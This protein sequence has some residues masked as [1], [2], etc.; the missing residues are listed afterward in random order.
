MGGVTSSAARPVAVPAPGAQLSGGTVPQYD[1]L[2]CLIAS[3]DGGHRSCSR[4]CAYG[5]CVWTASHQLLHW[6]ARAFSIPQSNNAM[7]AQGLLSC[8]R[9]LRARFPTTTSHVFGDSSVVINQ[10]LGRHSCGSTRLQP[11]I[12]AIRCLGTGRPL[13]YLRHIRR[14][15]SVASDALCNWIMDTTASGMDRT[16]SGHRWPCPPSYSLTLSPASMTAFLPTTT[17]NPHDGRAHAIYLWDLVLQELCTLGHL[18][19][20]RFMPS[21]TARP[22]HPEVF[23]PRSPECITTAARLLSSDFDYRP[24]RTAVI[25]G[26]E[27]CVPSDVFRRLQEAADRFQVAFPADDVFLTAGL[28]PFTL[29]EADARVLD[30]LIA[31]P[32][33]GIPGVLELFRGQTPLDYRPNKAL[34]P[35]LYRVHLPTYPQL[36]L[37]CAIAQHGLIP[38]WTKSGERRGVRPVPD[39]YIGA[40]TGASI[41][42]DKLLVDY[43]KGRCI[44]AS[45]TTLVQDPFFHSSAFALVLKKDKPIHLD[46][47]II[48]DLSAPMGLSVNNYTDFALSPDATWD[49]FL[50]IAL[51]IRELR[52]RYPGCAIYAMTADIADAFHHVPDHARHAS[53]FGGGGGGTTA[54]LTRNRIRHG[55]LWVDCIARFLRCFRTGMVSGYAETFWIFQWV[56]DIV[57]IEVDIDNPLQEAAKRLRD[58]VKLV[59]CSDGWHEGKFTTWSRE[60]HAVGIDW[61]IPS[62]TISVPQRKIDK[63]RKVVSETKKKRFVPMKQ[64]DSVVGVLR[65]V[66]SFIPTTKPFIQRLVAVQT[67]CRSSRSPGVPMSDFLQK[68]LLW[69][70]DLVFQNELSS[71]PMRLFDH[72]P[73]VDNAWLIRVEPVSLTI[74]SMAMGEHL[75]M[76]H[77]QHHD[78]DTTVAKILQRVV[79]RWGPVLTKEACWRHIVIHS[80]RRWITRVIDKMNCR[81]SE[82]QKELRLKKFTFWQSFCNDFGFPVW[83]DELS[84]TEQARIVGLYAGLC[85]SEGHNKFQTFDGKMA[86]VVF[87]H[88]AIRNARLNYHDPEFELITQGY[89]RSNSHV[90][91]K[92]P[93]TAQMLLKMRETLGTTDAH[94][95]LLWYSI[96]LAF[97][98]L[99]RSSEL[100]GPVS[101]DRSTGTERVHC[102]KAHNVSLKDRHGQAVSPEDS[103]AHVVEV[104]FESHKGDKV[105]QGVTIRH[106]K[107]DAPV[108]CPVAAAQSCLRIRSRWIAEGVALGPYITSIS[109]GETVKKSRVSKLIKTTA[110]NMGFAPKDY[111]AHS[112]RIGGACALLAAGKSDLVIRLMGR[113]SSWCFTVYTRLK[114]AIIRDAASS[115]IKASTWEFHESGFAQLEGEIQ[116]G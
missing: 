87:A 16:F 29:P 24:S 85:A 79:Q 1:A 27:R 102:L 47:R 49:P 70:E 31:A 36:E 63:M 7:E 104:R 80:D 99:D 43:Y 91:R 21:V 96:V 4:R 65:H 54:I 52:R 56:D 73:S 20:F 59:F 106:Y 2:P 14:G 50:V 112:L 25:A 3:F 77:D 45:I 81:S 90:D 71:I 78:L 18:I 40:V 111:S 15:Y 33:L 26:R 5:W 100:W 95:K 69:R 82:G 66:I 12:A 92:Q 109:P 6:E 60:F 13:L 94:D 58:G 10:A 39:N 32:E 34:R 42:T 84:R 62:E 74:R 19:H 68:D 114:P 116:R 11:W 97:F 57:L 41:V 83:I 93:V 55:R 64:L 23:L 38:H 86:A 61:S 67:R 37:L 105:G 75:R 113:W 46:G 53:V 22:C 88:K 51:R 35:W 28:G 48:H 89:K 72:N 110:A 30:E 76:P 107:S 108:L 98:F 8:L 9:W 101:V 103:S 44:I 115:M 17:P